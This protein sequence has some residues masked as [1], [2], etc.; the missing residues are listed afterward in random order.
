MS[1]RRLLCLPLIGL[2]SVVVLAGC[3]SDSG[4]SEDL[5]SALSAG[6]SH[7]AR[8][9]EHVALDEITSFDW[10]RV[11][12]V[13]PY[14]DQDAI[15]RQLG[16]PWSDPPPML[17]SEG[18]S[19]FVF[20]EDDEVVAWAP[21]DRS[22]ADPCSAGA[23]APVEREAATFVVGDRSSPEHPALRVAEVR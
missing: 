8:N 17:H 21:V 22:V 14:A 5:A 16:F 13:C 9:N 3:G 10:E 20:A 11:V 6:L 15:D 2:A 12:F 18:Q 1:A 4:G 23:P 19:L 7:G